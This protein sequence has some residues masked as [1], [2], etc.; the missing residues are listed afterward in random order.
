MFSRR[1]AAILALLASY[2][3][4]V[5]REQADRWLEHVKVQPVPSR[6]AWYMVHVCCCQIRK[7]LIAW[8]VTKRRMRPRV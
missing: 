1:P 6:G 8:C 3:G 5:V 7:I 4:S 2:T